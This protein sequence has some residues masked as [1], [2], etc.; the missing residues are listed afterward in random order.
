MDTDHC[1]AGDAGGDDGD[2]NIESISTYYAGGV[3][4]FIQ[5]RFIGIG[6]GTVSKALDGYVPYPGLLVEMS[7]AG[8]K[9]GSVQRKGDTQWCIREQRQ[10]LMRSDITYISAQTIPL[11]DTQTRFFNGRGLG[12]RTTTLYWDTN[13]TS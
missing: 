8:E 5:Q 13:T 7:Y 11:V 3:G 6:P 1:F 9:D 12:R 10:N 2:R 4:G